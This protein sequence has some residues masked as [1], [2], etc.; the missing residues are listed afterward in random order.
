[1]VSVGSWLPAA[2]AFSSQL[3]VPRE[4]GNRKLEIGNIS[5][6]C[7]LRGVLILPIQSAIADGQLK[8]LSWVFCG[9]HFFRL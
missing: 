6:C 1:M 2:L 3:P 8:I 5:A 7:V 9:L 4:S